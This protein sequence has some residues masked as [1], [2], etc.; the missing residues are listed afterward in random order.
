MASTMADISFLTRSEH[1]VVSL[2]AMAVRPRSR[3]EL[4]EMTGASSS[5][6]RRTLR[7]FEDRHWIARDGYQYETTELGA[8]IA[9]TMS[10]LLDRFETKFETDRE[11]T[12][13]SNGR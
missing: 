4:G 13:S 12:G 1:R 9:A 6:I 5:T 3:S 7:Q 11:D 2:V 10:D 8:F